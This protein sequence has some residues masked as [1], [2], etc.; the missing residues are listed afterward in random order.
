MRVLRLWM[1]LSMSASSLVTVA[2]VLAS[3]GEAVSGPLATVGVK[4]LVDG[5]LAGDARTVRGGVL[6]IVVGLAVASLLAA[7]KGPLGDAMDSLLDRHVRD[8]LIRRVTGIPSLLPHEDPEAADVISVTERGA[9]RMAHT[10]WTFSFVIGT[11]TSVATVSVV[12]ASVSPWLLLVLLPVAGLAA[13]GRQCGDEIHRTYEELQEDQRLVDRF[14][15][16]LWSPRHGVEIRCSGA[17]PALIARVDEVASFR[18]G[19]LVTASRR[20]TTRMGLARAGFGVAQ[21]MVVVA[22]VAMARS[23]HATVGDVVMLM[24]LVPQLTGLAMS[25]ME[26]LYGVAQTLG[27]MRNLVWLEDYARE[28]SWS[29]SVA[30]VPSRLQEGIS[31]RDVTFAYGGRDPALTDVSIDIGPVASVKD[32]D[33]KVHFLKDPNRGTIYDGPLIVLIN[34]ASASASEFLSAVL[35]D[36][37]RALIVGSTTYGKGTA[38]IVLPMDTGVI[39]GNAGYKDFVKV[40]EEKFYRVNGGTTQWKGVSPDID[41]PDLFTDDSYKERANASALQPDNSKAGIYQALPALPI[42]ALKSKSLQ[43]VEADPYF[44][45]VTAFDAWIKKYREDRIIPLQWS[46]FAE[47][48]NKYRETIMKM[49][50][51]DSPATAGITVT[52]NGFDRLR[53]NGSAKQSKTIN[54]TYLKHIQKDRTINEAYK[55]LMDWR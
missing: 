51:D 28:H 13:V 29:E 14:H 7:V 20:I 15:D 1:T 45:S 31:L 52:N 55:I 33:G 30:P 53:F 42:A 35:Q 21:G 32:K 17:G 6:L 4:A 16:I 44:T 39:A 9:W 8:L 27:G 43:R 5:G 40:T 24:L 34:G 11:V 47:D 3:V 22:G 37:N 54:E 23:G 49:K 46:G 26:G 41:L 12:L 19:K 2:L 50:F 10:G 38:Q 18:Q 25:L 48:Y 36:Y